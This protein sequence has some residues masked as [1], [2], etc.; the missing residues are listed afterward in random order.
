MVIGRACRQHSRRMGG[1][2]SDCRMAE[3]VRLDLPAGAGEASS[4]AERAG[5]PAVIFQNSDH[6]GAIRTFLDPEV[7]E[8]AAVFND[9]SKSLFGFAPGSVSRRPFRFER[10][11]RPYSTSRSGREYPPPL[12]T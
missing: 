4:D 10:H 8:L 11:G 12:S 7:A 2:E 1:R 3:G 9:L 5:N 6:A